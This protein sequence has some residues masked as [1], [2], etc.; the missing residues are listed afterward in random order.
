MA[1]D[2]FTLADPQPDL[3]L[4]ADCN[5]G[6]PVFTAGATTSDAPTLADGFHGGSNPSDKSGELAY[7]IIKHVGDA[8]AGTNRNAL[9]LRSVGSDAKLS[10]IE[11][12]SV[13]G[14]GIRIDGGAAELSN[15]LVYNAQEHG[16]HVTG[17]YLGVLDGVLVSQADGVGNS[18]IQ[19]DAGVGGTSAAEITDGMNT[20]AAARNLTCDVSTDNAGGAGVVGDRRRQGPDSKCHHC[21]H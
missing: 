5:L 16:I 2:P 7:V 12:Y 13:D 19:V 15:V 4:A 3:R 20:R 18:C 11:V 8:A 9:Q 1:N 17:G 10:N 14:S 21:R 6:G